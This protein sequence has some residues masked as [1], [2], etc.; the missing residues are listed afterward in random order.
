M[1]I[2]N[3]CFCAFLCLYLFVPHDTQSRDINFLF[4]SFYSLPRYDAKSRT[5]TAEQIKNEWK[6]VI[7]I[8]RA[9]RWWCVSV[10]FHRSDYK[11]VKTASL[12]SPSSCCV[13]GRVLEVSM[14]CSLAY[15]LI[16]IFVL[17]TGVMCKQFRKTI[18]LVKNEW[19]EKSQF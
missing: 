3:E 13:C 4:I 2:R 16:R 10:F 14:G 12:S 15:N 5:Q 6:Y 17:Q 1:R 8:V 9:R 19:R 11:C 7:F 18:I